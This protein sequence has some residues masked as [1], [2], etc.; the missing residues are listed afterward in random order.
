MRIT[1]RYINP[2]GRALPSCPIAARL[3]SNLQR[4][5]TGIGNP[6]VVVYFSGFEPIC[7]Y[8][9]HGGR[10]ALHQDLHVICDQKR[11]E[12]RLVTSTFCALAARLPKSVPLPYFQRRCSR[13]D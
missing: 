11:I 13:F 7:R 4:V 1:E 9:V 3:A 6:E 10:I 12:D 5:F 8:P 2:L